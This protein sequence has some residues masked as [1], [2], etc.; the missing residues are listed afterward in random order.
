MVDEITNQTNLVPVGCQTYKL[1]TQTLLVVVYSLN[2][3]HFIHA[4][5]SAAGD[6]RGSWTLLYDKFRN[7]T[8]CRNL[9]YIGYSFFYN[10]VSNTWGEFYG[11]DGLKNNDLIFM[12]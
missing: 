4:G 12:L 9:L 1:G 5:A 11:G 2:M 7:I 10:S 8:V 6:V 3:W